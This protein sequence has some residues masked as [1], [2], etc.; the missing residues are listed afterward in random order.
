[1]TQFVPNESATAGEWQLSFLT[2]GGLGS[3][4]DGRKH[5]ADWPG[6]DFFNRS[7]KRSSR[8][9]CHHARR[10]QRQVTVADRLG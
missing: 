4:Y 1:M 9:R 3:V 7:P 6:A 10:F 8:A 2:K 5:V